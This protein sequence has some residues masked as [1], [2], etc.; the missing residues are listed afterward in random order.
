V[1]WLWSSPPRAPLDRLHGA[2]VPVSD[3][4]TREVDDIRSRSTAEVGGIITLNSVVRVGRRAQ[5]AD[6]VVSGDAD[7]LEWDEPDP[8]V[9]PPAEF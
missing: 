7:V 8:P 5:G 3:S 9:I 4:R 2:E 6:F 1:F